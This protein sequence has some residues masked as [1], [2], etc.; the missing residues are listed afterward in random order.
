MKQAITLTKG[1]K[2]KIKGKVLGIKKGYNDQTLEVFIIDQLGHTYSNIVPKIDVCV[3][4]AVICNLY[5][6]LYSV[7]VESIKK[8]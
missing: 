3:K 5:E 6:N 4:D 7:Q 2:M 1:N 8:L